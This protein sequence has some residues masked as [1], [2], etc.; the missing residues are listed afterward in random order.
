MTQLKTILAKEFFEILHNKLLLAT[1]LAPLIIMP[2]LPLIIAFIT[3]FAAEADPVTAEDV[4]MLVQNMPQ[5][6]NLPY[7]DVLQIAVLQQMMIL[8]LII[9]LIVP[10]SIASFSIIGEKRL[11]TLEPLLAAPVS[12]ATILLGKTIAAALPG[13]VATWFSYLVCI[14]GLWFILS[15]NVVWQTVAGPTWWLAM[16]LAVPLLTFLSVM[17]GVIVSA[18]VNDERVAQQI[19]S[20]IVIPVVALSIG[21][22]AGFL[23]LNPVTVLVGALIVLALDALA[24]WVAVVLFERERILT[25]WAV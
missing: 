11:R 6:A 3:E 10:M 12:T 15:G 2:V 13:L 25:R 19:G 20:V 4:K 16:S 21:Q 1:V 18:R 7:Q 22:L 24:L 14:I 9:P 8:F 17:T 23:L 5:W